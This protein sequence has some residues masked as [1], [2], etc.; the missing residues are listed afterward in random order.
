MTIHDITEH[1]GLNVLQYTFG[2]TIQGINLRGDDNLLVITF[3]DGTRLELGLKDIYTINL[4][5]EVM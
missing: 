5:T 1:G 2:K 4:M 3:T